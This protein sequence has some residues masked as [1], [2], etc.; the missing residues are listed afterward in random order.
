MGENKG[1]NGSN[2]NTCSLANL[3]HNIVD[4]IPVFVKQQVLG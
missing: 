3:I 4:N 1:A 2:A